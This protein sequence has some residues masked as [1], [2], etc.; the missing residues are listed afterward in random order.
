M[1]KDDVNIKN[2][3]TWRKMNDDGRSSH[4]RDVFVSV[5]GGKFFKESKKWLWK[6]EEKKKKRIIIARKS[7]GEETEITNLSKYCK[8]NNLD[9]GAVYRVLTGERKHHKYIKFRIKGE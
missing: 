1:N 8:E 4:W 7:N 2:T 5:F 6:N 9:D 3:Q